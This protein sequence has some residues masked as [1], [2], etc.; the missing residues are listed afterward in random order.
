MQSAICQLELSGLNVFSLG[1]IWL[2]QRQGY[3]QWWDSG[4]FLERVGLHSSS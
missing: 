2:R 4:Q 1:S 3:S